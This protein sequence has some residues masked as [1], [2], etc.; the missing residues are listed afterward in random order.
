M[1]FAL[2]SVQTNATGGRARDVLYFYRKHRVRIHWAGRRRKMELLRW[3]R[4]IINCAV[5]KYE[6]LLDNRDSALSAECREEGHRSR[7]AEEVHFHYTHSKDTAP[8][9]KLESRLRQVKGGIW[10][11]AES[12]RSPATREDMAG[13][14]RQAI[15]STADSE[16]QLYAN[17]PRGL[18][19]SWAW[20]SQHGHWHFDRFGINK[21]PTVEPLN[22]FQTVPP[23]P[24]IQSHRFG[25]PT[26]TPRHL[27]Q[28]GVLVSSWMDAK[29]CSP[30][31][32]AKVS[33]KNQKALQEER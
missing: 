22:L 18:K 28:Q 12:F 14:P 13:G 11:P 25:P 17:E 29:L 4:G 7:W 1:S 15:T 10:A 24:P 23:P 8:R 33:Q 30:L 19:D 31:L 26:S 21:P 9:L 27:Q 20:V 6:G 5:L 32:C 16:G 3:R 2:F